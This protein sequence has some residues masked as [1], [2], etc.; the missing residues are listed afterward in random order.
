MS[1]C[2]LLYYL[3]PVLLFGVRVH[4]CEASQDQSFH[5]SPLHGAGQQVEGG[6]AAG[7]LLRQVPPA[8]TLHHD[9]R[10]EQTGRQ[11][12]CQR[13]QKNICT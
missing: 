2:T 3:S 12:V 9:V 7:K 4:V 6:A 1:Y 8:L 5:Q 13:L 10:P 11:T